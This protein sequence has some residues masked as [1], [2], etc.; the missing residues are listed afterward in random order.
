[1]VETEINDL[2]NEL[3]ST[4]SSLKQAEMEI[5]TKSHQLAD[6]QQEI[7]QQK[8]LLQQQKSQTE[9]MIQAKDELLD[10]LQKEITEQRAALHQ[11]IQHLKL[12]LDQVE[13][14]KTE[15]TTRLQQHVAACEREIERLKEMKRER[16]DLLHQTEEKVKDLEAKLS[17][18]NCLL[19]DKDQ[20]IIS[21]KDKSMF[22]QMKP[23]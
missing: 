1:M 19:A 14:Q 17:A 7:T 20:Q 2:K 4:F 18:A 12:Q 11:E 13:Q 6:Y 8:E 10:K 23:K 3:D 22:L 21:L 5:Q 9:E 15:Q 16:E